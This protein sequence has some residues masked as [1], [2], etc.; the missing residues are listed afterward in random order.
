MVD[1]PIRTPDVARVGTGSGD[2]G[3]PPWPQSNECASLLSYGRFPR[4]GPME[5]PA[6]SGNV[7]DCGEGRRA[8]YTPWSAGPTRAPAPPLDR[9][10]WVDLVGFYGEPDESVAGFDEPVPGG[11]LQVGC[12]VPGMLKRWRRSVDGRW[13]GLV[14]FA[15]CDSYGAVQVR[16]EAVLVPSAALTPREIPPHR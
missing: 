15:V 12:R 3:Q 11:V 1:G 5:P 13:F 8:V 9:P 6:T 4:P 2:V 10:V 7:K 14:N 16:H